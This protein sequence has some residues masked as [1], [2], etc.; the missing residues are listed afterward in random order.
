MLNNGIILRGLKSFGMPSG[1]R[2]SIG[3]KNEN[4]YFA[5]ILDNLNI[6]KYEL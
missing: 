1:V 4:K 3:N 2:I 6:D 5:E